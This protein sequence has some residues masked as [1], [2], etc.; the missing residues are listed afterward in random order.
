MGRASQPIYLSVWVGVAL[1]LLPTMA[2]EA[3]ELAGGPFRVFAVL[4]VLTGALIEYAVWTSGLGAIVLN[5]FGTPLPGRG[6]PTNPVSQGPE[7]RPGTQ[8]ILTDTV[9]LG[10]VTPESRASRLL[11]YSSPV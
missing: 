3:F 5:R 4:L 6:A 2:G 10:I 8:T 1:M 11:R 9:C 7:P